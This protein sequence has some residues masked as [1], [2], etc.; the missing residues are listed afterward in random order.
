MGNKWLQC[1]CLPPSSQYLVDASLDSITALSLCGQVSVRF[2]H[3]DT[4]FGCE[5]PFS[6]PATNS[7]LDWGL[8]FD[9]ATSEHSPCFLLTIYLYF[10]ALILPSIFTSLPGP[11]AEKHPHGTMLPPPCFTV[12]MVF[13]WWH[14]VFGV[15]QTHHLAWSFQLALESPKCLVNSNWYLMSVLQQWLSLCHSP[16]KLWLVK[17]LGN[18]CMQSLSHL[19]CW[20]F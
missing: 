4:A 5:Q 1:V 13:L 18:S 15:C 7:V 9:S 19:S 17:N 6:S 3:L 2:A 11:A 16:I 20:S 12:G 14:A 10:S 8:D